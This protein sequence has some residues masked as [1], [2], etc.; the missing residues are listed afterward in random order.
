MFFDLLWTLFD[1]LWLLVISRPT[2][3]PELFVPLVGAP[4][5]AVS[6]LNRIPLLH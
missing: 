1:L 2:D 3:Q 4:P 5:G 6:L